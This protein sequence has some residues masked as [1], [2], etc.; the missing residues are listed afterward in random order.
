MNQMRE[1][2]SL[3]YASDVYTISLSLSPAR[4][5]IYIQVNG[6]KKYDGD[7]IAGKMHGHGAFTYPDGEMYI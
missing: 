6:S 7:W 3:S 5:A 1:G 2:L 4:Q